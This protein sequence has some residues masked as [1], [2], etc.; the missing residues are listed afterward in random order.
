MINIEHLI[1]SVRKLPEDDRKRFLARLEE[2]GI[3]GTER[4]K[5]HGWDELL[6]LAGSVNRGNVHISLPDSEMI[7]EDRE[8]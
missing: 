1:E 8:S 4:P 5:E 6:A 3:Q 7:Y 2:L